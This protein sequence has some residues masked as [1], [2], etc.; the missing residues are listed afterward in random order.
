M[1]RAPEIESRFLTG[2]PSEQVLTS[3]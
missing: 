2:M 1:R 3:T